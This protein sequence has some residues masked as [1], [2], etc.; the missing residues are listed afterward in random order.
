MARLQAPSAVPAAPAPP[1]LL[2]ANSQPRL[3]KF[4]A[5]HAGLRCLCTLRA[6]LR[7]S[8]TSQLQARPR[9]STL[10]PNPQYALPVPCSPAGGRLCAHCHCQEHLVLPVRGRRGGGWGG[11]RTHWDLKGRKYHARWR[12]K[13]GSHSARLPGVLELIQAALHA[14]PGAERAES[15]A[16]CCVC[17]ARVPPSRC[18]RPRCFPRP[19]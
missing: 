10:N 16:S 19:L 17:S 9:P 14:L 1:R 18:M 4:H 2:P 6:P 13:P 7:R 5:C 12:E 3:P 8:P 15:G 11:R